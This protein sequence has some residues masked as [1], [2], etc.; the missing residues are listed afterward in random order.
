MQV[1]NVD[2]LNLSVRDFDNTAD[3]YRRVFGFE[4][5]EEDIKEGVRWGVIRSNDAMLCI[6][7]H[8]EL[9]FEDSP[10]VQKRGLHVMSHF[11]LRVTDR[12]EW[13]TTVEREGLEILYGGVVE[14]PH[15]DSW[16]INDPTGYE[17]EVVFWHD[18]APTFG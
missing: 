8:P 11:A 9:T 7:Q 5:V 16:Y 4:I 12:D 18:G 15:S 6:Y 13:L 2:H 3:W 1:R 10:E 17:I 14:W